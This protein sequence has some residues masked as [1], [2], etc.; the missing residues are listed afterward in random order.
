VPHS[1]VG[2]YVNF[3]DDDDGERVRA[4]YGGN[5][6]RLVNI[7]RK[8]DPDNLFRVNQNIAP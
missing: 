7:K 3:M 4:N 8:Y 6:D 2:G 5:F 1:E